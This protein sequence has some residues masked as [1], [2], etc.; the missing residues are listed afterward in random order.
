MTLHRWFADTSCP[1]EYLA[2]RMEDIAEKVNERL[3][4][5]EN[6]PP[7]ADAGRDSGAA[8]AKIW[9]VQAGAYLVKKNAEKKIAALKSAGFSAYANRS[10]LLYVVYAGAYVVRSNAEKTK[11]AVRAAGFSAVI[12]EGGA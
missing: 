5:A 9:R 1:G 11:N 4:E 10:G 8:A 2:G 3:K 7:A 6:V 12:V